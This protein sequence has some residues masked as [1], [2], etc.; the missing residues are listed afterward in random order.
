MS[1]LVCDICKR[2]VS[3]MQARPVESGEIVCDE[4]FRKYGGTRR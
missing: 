4:C 2:S 3:V 1:D